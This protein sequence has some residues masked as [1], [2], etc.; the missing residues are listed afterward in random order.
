MEWARSPELWQHRAGNGVGWQLRSSP[1]FSGLQQDGVEVLRSCCSDYNAASKRWHR[2]VGMT[3]K[4]GYFARQSVFNWLRH[5][6]QRRKF[7]SEREGIAFE[8]EERLQ[9][10]ARLTSL[11]AELNRL[12]EEEEFEF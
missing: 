3:E 5:E 10:E 8:L 1:K 7:L 4:I 12:R 2:A 6:V 11:A 9:L